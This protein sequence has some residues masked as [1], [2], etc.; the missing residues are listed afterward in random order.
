[1]LV[2]L[3]AVLA[4]SAML[5]A[6]AILTITSLSLGMWC[7]KYQLVRVEN[8][9]KDRRTICI[10]LYHIMESSEWYNSNMP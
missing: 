3:W 8:A 10:I 5:S 7:C 4:S 6:K 2:Y 9:S 1:M